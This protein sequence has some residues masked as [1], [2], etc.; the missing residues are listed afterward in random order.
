MLTIEYADENGVSLLDP[1]TQEYEEGAAYTV[2]PKS[3]PG[4]RPLRSAISGTIS[5]S[6]DV[7]FVYG[8]NEQHKL[9]IQ[10][11]YSDGTK[12]AETYTGSLSEGEDY[13]EASPVLDGCTADRESISGTMGAE[14]ISATVTY[15]KKNFSV[16]VNYVKKDGTVVSAPVS[17][18]AE[19]GSTYSISS[20]AVEGMTADQAV[21]SGTVGSEDT[22][23]N[24]TYSED[25]YT[26]TIHYEDEE[27]NALDS[28]AGSYIYG[29]EYAI[30]S[31]G[32]SGYE[33]GRSAVS[34]RI[35]GDAVYTVVYYEV[36]TPAAQSQSDT[37]S[38]NSTDTNKNQTTYSNYRIPTFTQVDKVYAVAKGD[39]FINIRE[40]KSTTSRII[41]TLDTN[42]VC[43]VLADSDSDW[44]Y[45]ESGN[46]RGFVSRQYLLMGNEA[47]AYVQSS[48]ESNLKT[49]QETISASQNAAYRYTLT[50]ANNPSSMMTAVR[51]LMISYAEQFLG[52]PYV[53]GGTSLTNGCDC[54]GFVQQIYAA[55][56][57]TLPR[58]SYEQAEAGTKI[59]A[60]DAVPGD[61]IFY[62]K[63]GVVYHVLMYIGNGQAVNAAGS[64][65]GI[66][67]SNVDY[68]KACWACNFLSDMTFSSTQA[69]NWV[70]IGRQATNG[71]TSAQQ[72]II[73]VLAQAANKEWYEYGFCRSVLIAQAIQES[74]WLS[75]SGASVG[76]IQPADNNILGMNADLLND[77]WISKWTGTAA[78]RNVPQSVNG[79][80]V[81]GYESMRTYSDI[82]SCMEDYAAFKI[83]L[84]PDMKG[85]TNT[86]TVISTALKG[87]A[88]DPTYYEAIRQIIRKYNLT[89]YDT[90]GFNTAYAAD[91]ANYTTD[92]L[93]LIYAV[94]A[95]EDD[96]SY[97][98]ALGVISCAMNRADLNYGGYGTTALAQL[99][100]SG[101]F[102]YSP[103]ISDPSY[104][105]SRLGGNV[106]DFVKQAVS[107]C[108]TKGIR[109]HGYLNFRSTNRTGNYIQ[110]GTNWYF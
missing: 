59:A 90:T 33:A 24:V 15:T 76:G 73:N 98:G 92:E 37:P 40:G 17:E 21:V 28:Y 94:V 55:F 62:A 30:P 46:V 57:V 35:T 18:Q 56:G 13:K 70:E 60:E 45:V 1:V 34:G 54:S 89:R 64:A 6:T 41:G 32:I 81:Y 11:V 43:C 44:V 61:L 66:I 67:I 103:S 99:T 58:C 97:E 22:V 29:Q 42:G 105:Q 71:D 87:Y 110:V 63:N 109:N 53:W 25:Q 49:A 12:A 39:Q 106:A 75:F 93:N 3:I 51:Q 85:V 91:T 72:Q 8:K 4:Y 20:P 26:L 27:G 65:T 38:T 88:T 47:A 101:Q 86:D 83:G 23:V 77:T 10:Y 36:E 9:T 52:N 16:T 68:S 2:L 96:A 79:K 31:P 19:Y 108:L 80:D 100:A 84:H 74:G 78:N 48:G 50:T 104:W 7:T 107:D 95:Q 14:D 102:C 5:R 69:T 82:E